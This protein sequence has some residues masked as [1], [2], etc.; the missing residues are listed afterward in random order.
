[1]ASSL[2]LNRYLSSRWGRIS[3][4]A[5]ALGLLWLLAHQG[6]GT[7]LYL[8]SSEALPPGPP[9]DF[10]PMKADPQAQELGFPSYEDIWQFERKL[11]QHFQPNR[12]TE[13]HPRPRYLFV[14]DIDPGSGWN[15]VMQ[16]FLLHA[17][18]ATL[19]D[20]SMVFHP[21]TPRDHA[22]LPDTLPSGDRHHIRIPLNAIISGASTGAPLLPD[23]SDRMI[24]RAVSIEYFN[25]VCG[26]QRKEIGYNDVMHG[27]AMDDEREGD[28]RM[29]RWAKK[30]KNM[31]DR[32]VVVT[33]G[34]IFPWWFTGG[35]K[36]LSIWP[37][38]SNGSTLREFA[39]SPLVTKTIHD[40][41][42]LLTPPSPPPA[43]PPYLQ[44]SSSPPARH[45]YNAFHPLRAD[46]AP[47]PGLLAIHVRRGDYEGHCH[48]L[49]DVGS[50]YTTFDKFGTPGIK[51]PPEAGTGYPGDPNAGPEAGFIGSA[52]PKGY[53]YP[54]LPDYL[55]VPKGEGKKEAALAHC[56]PS[57][58]QITK[59]A[60]DIRK[61]ASESRWGLS[62]P[63]ELR[64]V[65]ISTNGKEDWV[66][67]LADALK[68]DGWERV[69]SSLDLASGGKMSREALT[70]SQAVDQGIMGAAES[71]IGVGFSSMTGN[72]VQVRLGGGREPGSI[73]FW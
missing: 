67:E 57:V 28:E 1:M 46:A 44:P 50:E 13:P 15:N 35:F 62:K 47:I 34:S 58:A 71:F 56:W 73:H 12:F 37:A 43:I 25:A 33:G 64:S 3:V 11:G 55:S 17:H 29:M 21:F 69:A 32:C 39:W 18:L 20:R 60:N 9:F 65:Y 70:V 51:V 14:R 5:T 52:I 48:F 49:A 41:Y 68:K 36:V 8:G 6:Y 16:E 45:S 24:R 27:F 63:Q 61:G 23:A 4:G 7:S 66:K 54:A 30:L 2:T 31:E 26:E 22:P 10:G 72:V 38:Y 59:R 40:H 42:H 53:K 19:S